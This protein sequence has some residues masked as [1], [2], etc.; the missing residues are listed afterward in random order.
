MNNLQGKRLLLLGSNLWK[1]SIRQFAKDNGIYLIFTG[2]TSGPLDEIVDEYHRIDSTDASVMIPFIKD[3]DIN[4]I[5]MGG[6]ELVISKACDYINKLGYPCYCT[7]SQ[8]DILQNKRIFKDVCR[9]YGVPIVPE[10]GA[11]EKLSKEDFPV[12]VKPI[13]SCGSRGINVCYDEIQFMEAKEKALSASPSHN[14]LIERY[15][16]NGGLTIVASYI[17]IEGKYYLDSIGDRYVLNG[18]LITA[19][20]FFPSKFLD[21][22]KNKVDPMAQEMMKGL[23]IK[24]GVISF[25]AL[26]EGDAIFVYECCFRLTGGMTYKMTEAICGHSSFKMLFNHTL[27]GKMGDDEDVKKIDA[28]FKGQKGISL[29]IPLKTGTISKV[30][31]I[32]KIKS[33]K[34][35]IDYTHYYEVGDVVLPQS[36]NTLDQL[37][38]RIMVVGESQE[39]LMNTLNEIRNKLIIEDVAGENMIIWDT[40]DRLYRELSS[41]Y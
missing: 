19:A 14:C 39:K 4:G 36:I 3:H 29:T 41:K 8:W 27:T 7:K 15:V 25:Q 37:F 6:S 38:A 17:A 12:I 2:K 22:W 33:L 10:Y 18:G 1:E 9:K 20:A 13:D 26:P 34:Q 31:G 16:D 32:E 30:E 24:D 35:V 40:F 23:G 5:F 28:T 21:N 11:E